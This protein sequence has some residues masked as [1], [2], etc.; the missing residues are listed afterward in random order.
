[1]YALDPSSSRFCFQAIADQQG[2]RKL[3]RTLHGTLDKVRLNF[4]T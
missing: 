1:L 3:A 4:C 2:N